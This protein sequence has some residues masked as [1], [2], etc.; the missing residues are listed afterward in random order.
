MIAKRVWGR[1]VSETWLKRT[2]ESLWHGRG[3]PKRAMANE[4]TKT[5]FWTFIWAA[6]SLLSAAFSLTMV[7]TIIVHLAGL[8]DEFA[9]QFLILLLVEFIGLFS[10]F[11]IGEAGSAV[12]SRRPIPPPLVEQDFGGN[13]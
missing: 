1:A 12:A 8:A 7:A 13:V 10:I 2:V 5:A 3:R 9:A 11:V 6:T 4:P